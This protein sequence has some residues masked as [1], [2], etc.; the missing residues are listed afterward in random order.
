MSELTT[1][2][3]LDIKE[4]EK[5]QEMLKCQVH[6]DEERHGEYCLPGYPDR[7]NF[8]HLL[9][10]LRDHKDGLTS[11][12]DDATSALVNNNLTTTTTDNDKHRIRLTDEGIEVAHKLLTRREKITEAAYRSLSENEQRDLDRII[13]ILLEDYKNRDVNYTGLNAICNCK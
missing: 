10:I 11:E 12:L 8:H 2:L 13:N 9:R 4:F 7:H 3:F 6:I 5:Y 1:K